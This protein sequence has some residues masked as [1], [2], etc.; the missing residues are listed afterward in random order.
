MNRLHRLNGG[1]GVSMAF[2]GRWEKFLLVPLVT[3]LTLMVI[4]KKISW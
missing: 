1:F 4:L 3:H 2:F